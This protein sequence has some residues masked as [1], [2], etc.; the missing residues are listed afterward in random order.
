M[1]QTDLSKYNNS[2][3]NPGANWLIRLV[4]YCINACI[5]NSCFPF[6]SVKVFFLKMFGAT[7]GKNVVIKPYVNIKYPWNISIGDNVWIGEN[8][9]LDSLGKI[10]IGNNACISQR[11]MLICGNHN[12]KKTTFDLMVGDICLENG[13]WIGTGAIVCGGVTCKSHAMLSAGSVASDNLDEYS[14]YQG[15]PAIK[16]KERIIN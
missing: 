12:Y 14:V 2:W 15:N 11:A 6:S 7:V 16:I 3:Y 4:W 13:V 1:G 9:W 5:I 10:I 8:V